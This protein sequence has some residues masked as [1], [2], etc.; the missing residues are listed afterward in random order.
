MSKYAVIDPA[1]GELVKAYQEA[2]DAE[3]ELALSKAQRAYEEWSRKTTLAERVELA[4]RAA[5]LFV[6][7]KEELGALSNREMGKLLPS[8][9]G[10]AAYSGTITRTFAD[11]AEEWLA[12]EPVEANDGLHGFVRKQGLGV[13]LGI[14]PWNY[15]YYQVARFAAP[16]LILGNTV[17][18]KHANQCPESAKAIEQVFL[19]AGFPE[20]A[21]VNVY[22]THDQISTIIADDRVQ[23]VSLTG[24]ERAGAIVAEQA[25]RHLKKAVLELGGSD[26]FIVLETSDIDHA[27]AQAVSARLDNTGQ[28]C[29]GSKRIIVIDAHYDEF[30]EKFTTAI[31]AKSYDNG[32]FAPLSSASATETLREQVQA[33]V[34]HGA[35]LLVG[36]LDPTGNVFTPGVLTDITPEMDVFSEE[37]FGPVAQLYRVADEVEAIRLANATPYGLG[38]VIIA[39]DLEQAERVGNQLDTG[40][41]FIGAAGLEGTDVPFGGVKRSGFGRELGKYGFE[42]F[43]NK[44]LFRFAK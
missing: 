11:K 22:A 18:V 25:G 21:Y 12:D 40:M 8:A 7:R 4:R 16:N 15:P 30:A 2:T 33:A 42:E 37:L 14:M 44:K 23:G 41:V 1:T 5:D 17:I 19:D 6:E 43:A 10:E 13:I 9:I 28:S 38:S 39:D 3:I 32:D 36:D 27:V 34:D 26:P 35:K 29:N 20:G 24:S 31:G